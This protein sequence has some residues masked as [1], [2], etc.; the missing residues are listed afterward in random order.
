MRKSVLTYHEDY[1]AHLNSVSET[2]EHGKIKP[3]KIKERGD[4]T[5]YIYDKYKPS[6]YRY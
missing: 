3:M 6:S 2:K 4:D 5:L 1:L